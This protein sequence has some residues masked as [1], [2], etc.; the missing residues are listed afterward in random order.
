MYLSAVILAGVVGLAALIF[1]KAGLTNGKPTVSEQ[2][3]QTTEW[4]DEELRRMD[5]RITRRMQ[6]Y[7]DQRLGD[8]DLFKPG[9]VNV[10]PS[11][12]GRLPM[13]PPADGGGGELSPIARAFELLK[14]ATAEGS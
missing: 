11:A 2:D 12:Q 4:L 3:R 7:V 6:R 8:K 13:D 9:A 14:Q 1:K 10:A 5:D